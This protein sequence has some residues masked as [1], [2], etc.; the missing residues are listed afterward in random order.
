MPRT[1]CCDALLVLD[2]READVALAARAEARA[3]AD[4]DLRLPQQ[5]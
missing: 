5:P 2:E 1:A 4:R 3:G